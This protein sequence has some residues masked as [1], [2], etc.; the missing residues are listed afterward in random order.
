[1]E[2]PQ[3]AVVLHFRDGRT[4]R[5]NSLPD[6]DLDRQSVIAGDLAV[7]FGELKAVFFR[8]ER[9]PEGEPEASGSLVS[10][11]FADGEV[12]R[13]LSSDYTPIAS[14]FYLTPLDETKLLRVFV[15]SSSVVAIEVEKL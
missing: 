9:A 5:E 12:L 14:G 11:E 1:M 4:L 6:I 2:N 10:V 13:G 7:P 15:V 8:R 3:T